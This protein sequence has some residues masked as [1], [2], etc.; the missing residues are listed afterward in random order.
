MASSSTGGNFVATVER[1][2][3][4]RRPPMATWAEPWIRKDKSN[5]GRKKLNP[6]SRSPKQTNTAVRPTTHK[7]QSQKEL[8]NPQAI[9][10][11]ATHDPMMAS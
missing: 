5:R 11:L 7:P 1:A 2:S 6:E 10:A 4:A 8:M 3:S 9:A